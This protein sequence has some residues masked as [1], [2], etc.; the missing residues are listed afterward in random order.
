MLLNKVTE[1]KGETK[2]E[3]ASA[4]Q[5]PTT[6]I[7]LGIFIGAGIDQQPHTVRA[8]FHSGPHQ[9]CRADLR[10]GFA[11]CAPAQMKKRR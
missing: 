7:S 11:A 9:R 10:V 8:A 5:R 2:R 3:G 1:R 4:K 6:H